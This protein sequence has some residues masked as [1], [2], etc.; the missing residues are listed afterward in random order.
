MKKILLLFVFA[1]LC[2]GCDDDN[3]SKLE[4]V[5]VAVPLTMSLDELRSSVSVESAQ[6]IE[7]SGKIYT[8]SLFFFV[9]YLLH[10]S[11][12]LL[13]VERQRYS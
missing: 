1:G 12:F 13:K 11:R 5:Q 8:S 9:N 4:R 2:L 3:N 7:E 10:K 6:S